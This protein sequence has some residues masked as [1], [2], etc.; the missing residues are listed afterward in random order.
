MYK[1]NS[2]HYPEQANFSNLFEDTSTALQLMLNG[3]YI[4]GYFSVINAVRPNNIGIG[5]LNKP[6]TAAINSFADDVKAFDKFGKIM[7]GITVAIQVGEGVFNDYN[8]GQSLDRIMSNA[9]V[10]TIVYCASAWGLARIGGVI[11]NV[12]PIPIVGSLIGIAAGYLL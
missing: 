12:I 6:R 9:V 1:D 4:G 10:N 2:G 8:R 7:A 3:A 5:I 11:G